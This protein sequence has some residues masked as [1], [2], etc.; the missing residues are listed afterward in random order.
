MSPVMTILE[1]KPRR[2]RNIFICSPGRVLGLVE[3][4]EAV[5][6]R[7]A[8][9]VGQGRDL[10]VAALE[11]FVVGLRAEHVEQGVVER[12]QVGVDLV[13]QI[14]GQKAQAFPRLDGGAGQ[15]DAVDL[16]GPEGRARRAATAR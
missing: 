4:D 2:V 16:L 1:S 14:A 7:A 8:A 6:Q 12:A 13:L 15:D 10:D 11:I 3:D 9:H 5:V